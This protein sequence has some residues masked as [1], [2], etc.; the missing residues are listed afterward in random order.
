MR[1]VWILGL[2]LMVTACREKAPPEGAV[3]VSVKYGS[4]RPGCLRVVAQDAQGNQGSTDI[5]QGNFKSPEERKIRVG[6]FRKA[7]WGR[8]LSLTVSSY[9]SS[10]GDTCSGTLVETHST[11]SPLLVPLGDFASFEATLKATD[12]DGD[13]YIARAEGVNGLDCDDKNKEVFPGASERCSVSVDYDCDGFKGCQDSKCQQNACDDDNACTTN[14]RC[15]GTGVSAQCKGQAVQCKKPEGACYTASICSQETGQCVDIKAPAETAC[16]DG[17]GCTQNDRCGT[18][19]LCAGSAISCTTPQSTCQEATGTCDASLGRCVYPSKPANSSCDDR[20]VCTTGDVC[21]GSG[22]CQGAPSPC[23]PPNTCQRVKSGCEAVGNCVYE[24][25][26]GR[27]DSQCDLPDGSSAGR[28]RSTGECSRFPYAPSNFNPDAIPAASITELST[29]CPVTFDSTTLAWSPENCVGRKPE[30]IVLNSGGG[31]VLLPIS[32]M[33]LNGDLRF[34]GNRPVILAVYGSATLNS[35]I[36]ANG[37]ATV[38]G[39]GGGVESECELRRGRGGVFS[40]SVGGGGGG[41]GGGTAGAEGGRGT[42]SGATRGDGG[43]AG[44]GVFV[45]LVGGCSGG[46]G[47]GDAEGGRGGGGGGSVQIS[48]AGTLTVNQVVSVSGGGGEGGKSTSGGRT[49]G[50]GGGGSGGQI[51]LEAGQLNLANSTKLTANG[52]AGGEGSGYRSS[53]NIANG[54]A[55]DNGSTWQSS[56]A[57]GGGGGSN[58]GGD[59]GNGG[60][61]DRSPGTGSQGGDGSGDR[62]GGGGGGGAVGHIR[63]RSLRACSIPGNAVISPATNRACPL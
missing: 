33:N 3:R 25:I 50:A 53:N 48:V 37:L 58:L 27:V 11:A 45:P 42:Q 52:G 57:S 47:G 23:T 60:A 8:E 46:G 30:P 61:L 18:E 51:L 41:A 24:P 26:P 10:T 38:P 59:G 31:M 2:L 20:E 29:S 35:S 9:A 15:E 40:N 49:G 44:G 12:D 22:A 7:E 62:G 21:N 6:V 54:N 4:Y 32:N 5:L 28:C 63:L 39:A 43:S 34:V 55:G 14:D 17:N 16:D 56:Q 19:A 36:L 1:R 13:G